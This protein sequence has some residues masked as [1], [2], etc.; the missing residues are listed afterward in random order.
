[1]E[2]DN[3]QLAVSRADKNLF[4]HLDIGCVVQTEIVQTIDNIIFFPASS[5]KEDA[6][7]D[8]VS[9]FDRVRNNLIKV[10]FVITENFNDSF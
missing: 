2:P 7:I 10:F 5:A 8:P 3:T 4:Q 1:M 6:R 9:G